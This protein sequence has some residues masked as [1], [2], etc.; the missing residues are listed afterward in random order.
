MEFE[1]LATAGLFNLNLRAAGAGNTGVLGLQITVPT[2]LRF[3][4]LGSGDEDPT[5]RATF[6]IF[7][8]PS[9]IIFRREV[10]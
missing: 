2:H 1:P 10:R 8:R 4:W 5:A 6:G 9:S 7:N 3:D